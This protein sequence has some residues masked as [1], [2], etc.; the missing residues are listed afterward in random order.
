MFSLLIII[1]RDK[2]HYIKFLV[3]VPP[4]DTK[5]VIPDFLYLFSY[6]LH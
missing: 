4:E 5:F 1:I 2:C 3:N 6:L